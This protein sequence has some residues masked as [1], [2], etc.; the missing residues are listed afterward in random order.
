V[1]IPYVRGE[2]HKQFDNDARVI[3]AVYSGIDSVAPTAGLGNP[4]FAITTDKPDDEFALASAGFSVV[5]KRGLQG[6]IQYQQVFDL[7]TYHD[8]AITGGL[9]LEF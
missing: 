7:D 6:F 4:D 8:R 9:R 2:F 5:L 1:I 3:N